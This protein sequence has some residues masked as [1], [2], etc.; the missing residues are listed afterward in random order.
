ML[1]FFGQLLG[2]GNG[3]LGGGLCGDLFTDRNTPLNLQSSAFWYALLFMGLLATLLLYAAFL[4]MLGLLRDD[5][6]EVLNRGLERG[7]LG[8]GLGLTGTL[9]V[10]FVLS[11]STGLPTP[12]PQGMV[13][14]EAATADPLALVLVGLVA[15]STLTLAQIRRSFRP[16]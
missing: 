4:G 11:R 12:S 14:G 15:A 16:S 2:F 13:W 7:V 10:L 5:E 1:P 6:G 9:M 3:V 8:L